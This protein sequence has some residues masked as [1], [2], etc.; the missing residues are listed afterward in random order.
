MSDAV[1]TLLW[2]NPSSSRGDTDCTHVKVR[3]NEIGGLACHKVDSGQSLESLLDRHAASLRRVIVGGG[4]GT[5]N[6]ALPALRSARLPVGILPLG[7]ANDFASSMGIPQNIDQAVDIIVSGHTRTAAIAEAN[8]RPFLNAVGIGLGPT[9][10]KELDKDR[11][12]LLGVFGYLYSLMRVFG[13]RRRRRASMTIDNRTHDLRFIQ[14]TI[15]NGRHYG[16]GM[17]I[18]HDA[19]L[20]DGLLRVL[21]LRPQS[22]LELMSKFASLRWGTHAGH[23]G[24]MPAN[25]DFF[26]GV[27]V[28][29]ET[30]RR[31]HVTLDGEL[32]LSTPLT[33]K[34]ATDTLEVFCP[35]EQAPVVGRR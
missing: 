10:T 34:V 25:M 27:Q 33:C 24:D 6:H 22:A 9:L 14:I 32:V 19:V 20:D 29:L 35:P 15:A 23:D 18:A 21:C 31:M 11:K 4:D 26:E 1:S 2:V 3:L 28:E 7:T 8:G 17:T 12:R 16:G 5:L 30:D 13:A